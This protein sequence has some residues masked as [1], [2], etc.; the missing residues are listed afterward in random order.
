MTPDVAQFF[1]QL[2]LPAEDR[3][4][5]DE[6]AEKARHGTLSP[7]DQADLDEFRRLGRLVELMKLKARKALA[8]SN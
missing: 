8:V 7:S 1:L 5:L 2:E 4:K 3:A 6:L